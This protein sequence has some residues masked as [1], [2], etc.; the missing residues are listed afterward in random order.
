MEETLR[1]QGSVQ[2]GDDGG[3]AGKVAMGPGKV[4]GSKEQVVGRLGKPWLWQVGEG[5]EGDE[6]GPLGGWFEH[7]VRVLVLGHGTVGLAKLPPYLSE[8]FCTRVSS[9]A[10]L[11]PGSSCS[12]T[13]PNSS[14]SL[15][16]AKLPRCLPSFPWFLFTSL[17]SRDDRHTRRPMSCLAPPATLGSPHPYPALCCS[18]PP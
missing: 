7:W 4:D 10:A 18:P 2:V 1:S 6:G 13:P 11:G 12:C 8:G 15:L 17:Q 14:Q 5:E 9:R 3:W 16:P